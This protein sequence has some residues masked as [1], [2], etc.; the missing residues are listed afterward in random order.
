MMVARLWLEI[1]CCCCCY[2]RAFIIIS[3]ETFFF[4]FPAH[5]GEWL[6]IFSSLSLLYK[7]T[8]NSIVFSIFLSPSGLFS[9]YS[10]VSVCISVS[11]SAYLSRFV[12]DSFCI[13]ACLSVCLFVCL[14]VRLSVSLSVCPS[15]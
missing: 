7:F 4:I 8:R 12:Q 11:A 15:V 13:S 2:S 3:L 9:V 1:F 10:Y 14:S 5:L 6:W